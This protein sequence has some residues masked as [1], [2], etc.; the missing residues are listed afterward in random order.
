MLSRNHLA[1]LKLLAIEPIAE[2]AI[3]FTIDLR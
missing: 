1:K 2:S 3:S